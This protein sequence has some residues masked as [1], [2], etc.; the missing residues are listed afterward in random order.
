M[1]SQLA[2]RVEVAPRGVD[3]GDGGAERVTVGAPPWMQSQQPPW[4]G[5]VA[6]V[7]TRACSWYDGIF[8]APKYGNRPAP[9]WSAPS[10]L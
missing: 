1:A 3:A 4:S 7:T 10:S 5:R 8:H 9:E 6:T 2:L